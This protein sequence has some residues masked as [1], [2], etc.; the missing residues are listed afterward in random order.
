MENMIT[1]ESLS[2]E[3]GVMT[4]EKFFGTHLE[5][6]FIKIML[7]LTVASSSTILFEKND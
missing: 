4:Y 5:G 1:F 3:S 2:K 7:E 6:Y